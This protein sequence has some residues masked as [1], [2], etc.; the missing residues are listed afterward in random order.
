[1]NVP[2]SVCIPEPQ[3]LNL[4]H[5]CFMYFGIV[6]NLGIFFKAF[7]IDVTFRDVTAS[8]YWP[9]ASHYHWHVITCGSFEEI[10]YNIID[11]KQS[12]PVTARLK[13]LVCGSS[14]AGILSSNPVGG[15]WMSVSFVSV[16]C[17]LIEF[18]ATGLSLVQRSRTECGVTGCD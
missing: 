8:T 18:S 1:V 9:S 7:R 17:C 11:S 4:F 14:R 16:V 12:I 2:G 13:A 10:N 15:A 6:W 3:T 5:K